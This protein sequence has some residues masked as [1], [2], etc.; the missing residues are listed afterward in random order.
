METTRE[1]IREKMHARGVPAHLRDGLELYLVDRLA[2]SHFLHC[3]LTNDL[4]GTFSYGDDDAIDG[5]RQLVMFIYNDVPVGCW[6]TRTKVEQWLSGDTPSPY[7]TT[8]SPPSPT[9]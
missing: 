5:L 1:G 8:R 2:P 6:G 3:V 7:D 9:P 4:F